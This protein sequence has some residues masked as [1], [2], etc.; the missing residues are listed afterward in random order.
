MPCCEVANLV[1]VT[2]MNRIYKMPCSYGTT[3]TTA[4]RLWHQVSS[5][6]AQQSQPL[7]MSPADLPRGF[8]S[9]KMWLSYM[10]IARASWMY[11]HNC[12]CFQ[13]HLRMPLQSLR[14]LSLAPWGPWSIWKYFEALVRLAWV[15]VW[16]ACGFQTDLHFAAA[17]LIGLTTDDARN[18][19]V[20][21]IMISVI[22]IS[23]TELT[24][25]NDICFL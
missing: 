9:F 11:L 17:W 18:I 16:F 21:G 14:A 20:L 23:S 5:S 4:V 25:G 12:R 22:P 15:A 19:I 8:S 24:R 1:T 10:S 13:E 6:A 7:S 2:K 3:R